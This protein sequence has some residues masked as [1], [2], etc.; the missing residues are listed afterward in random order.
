[1]ATQ[2]LTAH[3]HHR[4][5]NE[6]PRCLKRQPNVSKVHTHTP[7]SKHSH[8]RFSLV[9]VTCALM[10]FDPKALEIEF[11]QTG[12][13]QINNYAACKQQGKNNIEALVYE[14][15]LLVISGAWISAFIDAQNI[16]ILKYEIVLKWR[17][18][19]FKAELYLDS[20]LY[21]FFKHDLGTTI[22]WNEYFVSYCHAVRY[23]VSILQD[24]QRELILQ[25]NL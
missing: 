21:L 23:N 19:E 11:W 20:N 10:T 8:T 7:Y 16:T 15:I 22:L 13:F 17:E 2:W 18:E 6:L 3:H 24:I 5:K 9:K 25:W 12:I 1:M 4:S 14:K